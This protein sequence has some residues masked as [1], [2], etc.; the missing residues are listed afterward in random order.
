MQE[1]LKLNAAISDFLSLWERIEVRAHCGAVTLCFEQPSPWPSPRVRGNWIASIAHRNFC[2]TRV[3]CWIRVRGDFAGPRIRIFDWEAV[4]KNQTFTP[5]SAEPSVEM[6]RLRKPRRAERAVCIVL[7]LI[8]CAIAS[9]LSLYQLGLLS[10]VWEP[11]FGNGSEL[12][13][14]SSL[15]RMLPVPDASLGAAAYLLEVVLAAAGGHE[16]WR[17]HPRLVAAYGLAAASL[18]VVAIVLVVY[19][20]VYVKAWCTLCLASA[21]ISITIALTAAGEVISALKRLG[22]PAKQSL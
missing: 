15:S 6:T 20:A 5:A 18:G 1:T 9:Y 16:R 13:L 22:Y 11:F 21:A 10:H 12:V 19:Q 17:T 2:R 14:H 4:V 8:G 7:G 3:Y